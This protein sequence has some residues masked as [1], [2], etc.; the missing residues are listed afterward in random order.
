VRKRLH[1]LDHRDRSTGQLD[2]IGIKR[3]GE[4]RTLSREHEMAARQVTRLERV[5]HK[6]APL[7][8]VERMHRH[9]KCLH[10]PMNTHEQRSA[11][12]KPGWA[13]V[14]DLAAF[15]VW[16]RQFLACATVSGDTYDPSRDQRNDDAAVVRRPGHAL[17]RTAGG[18]I[19]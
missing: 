18:H 15:E 12:W 1:V 11:A 8:R 19:R 16:F 7:A 3:R 6:D 13:V 4:E 17:A 14:I 9:I 10:T 5:L 2:S